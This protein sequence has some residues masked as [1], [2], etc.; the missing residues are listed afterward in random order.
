MTEIVILVGFGLMV[1]FLARSK[2][3]P[4]ST[5]EE[6]Q[7]RRL[8]TMAGLTGGNIE[9]AMIARYALGRAG[10]PPGKSDLRDEATATGMMDSAGD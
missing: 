4:K 3:L 2:P 1:L 10:K 9:D 8:A 6:E 7:A 5:P